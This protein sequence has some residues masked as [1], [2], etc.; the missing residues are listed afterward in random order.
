MKQV[1][2]LDTKAT[3]K[4]FT[5]KEEIFAHFWFCGKLKKNI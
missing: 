3:L 2:I 5:D 1:N 4:V